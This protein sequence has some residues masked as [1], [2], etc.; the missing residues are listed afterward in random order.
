[1][2]KKKSAAEVVELDFTWCSDAEG[3][4]PNDII[5]LASTHAAAKSLADLAG[6]LRR[7]ET[8]LLS[9]GRDGLHDVIRDQRASINR[10]KRIARAKAK[11]RKEAA[12]K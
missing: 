1:M 5:K 12:A 6:T 8:Y 11:A 3:C 2:I 4:W 7:I 10:K 9:L